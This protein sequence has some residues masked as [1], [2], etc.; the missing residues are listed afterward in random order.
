MAWNLGAKTQRFGDLMCFEAWKITRRH[1]GAKMKRFVLKAEPVK[2]RP[3]GLGYRSIP[4][5]LKR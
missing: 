4:F 5:S 3:F 1:Q 2:T